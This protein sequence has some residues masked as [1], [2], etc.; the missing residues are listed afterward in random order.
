MNGSPPTLLTRQDVATFLRVRLKT[1]TYLVWALDEEKRYDTFEIAR[2]AG[3]EPRVV[4]APIKPIKDLQ[5]KLAAWL[6]A[7][8]RPRN[9][10]HGFVPGRSSYTGAALHE[11]KE[12]V[13]RVDLQDFFPTIHFG[14]V[15]GVFSHDPFSYPDEAANL[16]AALCC[17]RQRLPQ[18]AP[19]SPILSN[20]VCR[21]LDSQLADLARSERCHFTRY[22]DDITFSTDRTTFPPTVG[23]LQEGE[24]VAGEALTE[25]I[26]AHN[27]AINRT[28]TRLQRSTQRQR[29]T[30]LVVNKGRNVP[31]NY[32]RGLRQLLYIWR[33]YSE[34]DASAALDRAAEPRDW[35][36]D[37]PKPNF[38]WAVAGRVNY[39]GFVKGWTDPVYLALAN[40]WAELDE[41]F[42]PRALPPLPDESVRLFCEGASD[43]PQVSAAQGYFHRQGEFTELILEGQDSPKWSD[44]EL[45]KRCQRL[46]ETRQSTC[47]ICLF[48]SDS[49]KI[50]TQAVDDATGWRDWG[51]GVVA[52]SLAPPPWRTSGERICIEML[53]PADVLEKQTADGR[54]VFLSEEFSERSSQHKSGAFNTPKAV[55]HKDGPL[56]VEPVIPIGSEASVSLSKMDFASKVK[57]DVDP[58]AGLTFD[59]FRP[60]FERIEH[61]ARIAS[62]GLRKT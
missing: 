12:W 1:L 47:C 38:R 40:Q 9:H 5:R 2:K 28:K 8:Y 18:G 13:L 7:W 37:K 29:V 61:A 50:L 24:S 31:R 48:D 49:P 19:T 25:L 32:V 3:R 21:G 44:S 45:L 54:R 6:V 15:R 16:L 33:T 14:R 27:F 42:S 62:L 30:G 56:V 46:A 22:A 34:A 35:P 51:N 55:R 26:E 43:W 52:V 60:T 36:P 17:H 20:Y 58:F 4:D 53:H 11:N 57:E 23:Y 39:V 10:V 41:N 59:G